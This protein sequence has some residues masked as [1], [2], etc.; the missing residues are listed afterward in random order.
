ENASSMRLKRTLKSTKEMPRLSLHPADDVHI[1]ESSPRSFGKYLRKMHF[2]SPSRTLEALN[3]YFRYNIFASSK[4]NEQKFQTDKQT[5]IAYYNSLGYR[6]A[7]IEK[8]TLYRLPNGNLN[9]DLKVKEGSRYYF[10]DI[11]W[12][13]NTK[14]TSEELSRV[15]GIKKGDVYN[16]EL[17]DARLGKQLSPEGGAD[18]SSLYMD[19][20]EERRVGKGGS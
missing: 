13:G 7:D 17:L 9:I 4:F 6:D 11:T 20:S 16:Q 15:L 5:L 14:Y 2:L 3:P 18:V 12:R 1:Y 8:D 19:R 10:G